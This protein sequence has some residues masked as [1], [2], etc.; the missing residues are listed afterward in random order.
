MDMLQLTD[1]SK[2]SYAPLTNGS[3]NR[4]PAQYL[5]VVKQFGVESNPRYTPRGGNTFC[6]IFLWDVTR[7]MSCEIPHWYVAYSKTPEGKVTALGN[8]YN[9]N[10]VC[11]W[12]NGKWSQEY[13]WK[14]VIDGVNAMARANL[15]FPTVVAWKN[16]NGVG[17]VGVVIP[18]TQPGVRIAQAGATNFVDGDVTRGF[19][20]RPVAYFTHD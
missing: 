8:E 11:D 17:H 15:G 13:G 4:G 19:G 20:H 12:L 5:A 6:N 18:G 1:A 10:A 7:H 16:P 2:P 9:A 14:S 3:D